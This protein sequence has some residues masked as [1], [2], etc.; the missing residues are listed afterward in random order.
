MLIRNHTMQFNRIT[1]IK[2]SFYVMYV[3]STLLCSRNIVLQSFSN[4]KEK[5]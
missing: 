1:A 2:F 5:Q 4:D 3:C